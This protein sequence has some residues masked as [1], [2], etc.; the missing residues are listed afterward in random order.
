MEIS[1]GKKTRTKVKE[2]IL[3]AAVSKLTSTKSTRQKLNIAEDEIKMTDKIKSTVNKLDDRRR[4]L[5]ASISSHRL[6]KRKGSVNVEEDV[7]NQLQNRLDKSNNKPSAA[8][9]ATQNIKK[10]GKGVGNN[11]AKQILNATKSS[12]VDQSEEIDTKKINEN[13]ES[14]DKKKKFGR[15]IGNI[16]R[17]LRRKTIQ[18]IGELFFNKLC[19]TITKFTLLKTFE[20][21]A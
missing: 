18:V 14:T 2:Q 13:S 11:I 7:F 20:F 16:G 19:A 1:S 17:K 6:F 12:D 5:D 8:A 15:N 21:A 4:S 3:F 9:K 10:L